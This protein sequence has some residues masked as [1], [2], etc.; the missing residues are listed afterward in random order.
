MFRAYPPGSY[1]REGETNAHVTFLI[2]GVG[3]AMCAFSDQF[4]AAS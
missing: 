1:I 3:I 4:G 2:N